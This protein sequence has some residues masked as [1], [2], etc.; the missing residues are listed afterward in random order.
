MRPHGD[1]I[2]SCGAKGSHLLPTRQR[3]QKAGRASFPGFRAINCTKCPPAVEERPWA[4]SYVA[5]GYV[6]GPTSG[7]WPRTILDA[8]EVTKQL[9]EKYL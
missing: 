4:E 6:W 5:L 2:Q 3:E 9:G 1:R 7:D 8:V